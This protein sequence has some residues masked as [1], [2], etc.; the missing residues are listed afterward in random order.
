MT[1][2]AVIVVVVDVVG[3]AWVVELDAAVARVTVA[4]IVIGAMVVMVCDV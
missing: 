3:V 1:A 4:V 2:L